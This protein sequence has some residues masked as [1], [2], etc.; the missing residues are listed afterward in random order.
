MWHLKI[1]V[2]FEDKNSGVILVWVITETTD[3]KGIMQ[4]KLGIR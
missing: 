2:A 1:N 4:G 3:L